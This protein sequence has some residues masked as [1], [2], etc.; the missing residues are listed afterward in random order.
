MNFFF[1]FNVK[2]LH[3]FSF[4][5]PSFNVKEMQSFAQPRSQG[6]SP[7]RRGWAPTLSSAEKSPGNEVELRTVFFFFF[8]FF[9][10][11][12]NCLQEFFY[13]NCHTPPSPPVISNGPPLT[14]YFC[15]HA[16][17]QNAPWDPIRAAIVEIG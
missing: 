11:R 3:D 10:R 16:F 5:S 14:K 17:H 6:F 1:F 15:G 2:A 13:G 8:F 4:D 9:F 7:P 12:V